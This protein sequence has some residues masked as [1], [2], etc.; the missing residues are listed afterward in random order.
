MEL[1]MTRQMMPVNEI[2][3]DSFSEQP[4]ECDILLPDY[5]PDIQRILHCNVCCMVGNT[6]LS[7]QRFTVSGEM[8]ISVLYTGDR[9]Q[10]RGL[11]HRVP[12]SR[13]AELRTSPQ[14]WI[15]D[16][17]CKIDYVN[18]RAVSSRRLEIRG[19]ATLKIK[20]L[21]CQEGDFLEDC[22]GMGVQLKK[23][24]EN[25]SC[26]LSKAESPFSVREEL[27]TG[28]HMPISQIISSQVQA[29]MTDYK[30]ISGKIIT[31]GELQVSVLYE[32]VSQEEDPEPE[33][34]S[35]T[36]PISQIMDAADADEGSTCCI[37]YQVTGWDI[38]PKPDLDGES[39]VLSLEV[40]LNGQAMIHREQQITLPVDCYCTAYESSCEVKP[41]S[42]LTL[43]K[44][45]NETCLCR[46][47]I[48]LRKP[49][50]SVICSWA[51]VEDQQ[52]EK[53][54]EGIRLLASVRLC[55]MVREQDGEIQFCETQGSV[56]HLIP[57]ENTD[58]RILFH[59]QIC[60]GEAEAVPVGDSQLEIKCLCTITGCVYGL[61][62]AEAISSLSV[63]EE[64]PKAGEDR[65]ALTIYYADQGESV[66]DIAKK[67]NTSIAGVMEENGLDDDILPQRTMLLIPML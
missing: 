30:V 53:T 28:D 60:A 33:V 32:P 43:I 57:L 17:A 50:R 1:H 22:T 41:V 61:R 59:P 23:E 52:T 67:Y 42:F 10:V 51:S 29:R 26:C 27:D 64:H 63:D 24:M 11:E 58:E 9:G 25:I 49:V 21:S 55:A 34:L 36:L 35:Y 65:C 3:F 5:C 15:A 12:F 18:C 54:A 56:S 46:E 14:K 2:I 48:S 39:K 40:Q 47:K 37:W 16:T 38:Q 19:A 4:V 31:K 7:G 66:W 45:V 8:R 13:S 44:S 62:R 6:Q 20:I